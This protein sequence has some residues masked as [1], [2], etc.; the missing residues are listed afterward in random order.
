MGKDIKPNVTLSGIEQ[1]V[2]GTA[3]FKPWG[4]FSN[5]EILEVE[6]YIPDFEDE[7]YV[8]KLKARMTDRLNYVFEKDTE[9]GGYN[10]LP[11]QAKE[12]LAKVISEAHNHV[13]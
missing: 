7:D 2:E 6:G 5:M 13:K 11:T 12:A 8:N 9:D 1:I 4:P 3:E 10:A